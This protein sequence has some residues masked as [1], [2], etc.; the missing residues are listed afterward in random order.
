[1]DNQPHS[2]FEPKRNE[3]QNGPE[4]IRE[5][6]EALKEKVSGLSDTLGAVEKTLEEE[7]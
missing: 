7:S 5:R 1:M 6:V 2:D 3:P 4:N